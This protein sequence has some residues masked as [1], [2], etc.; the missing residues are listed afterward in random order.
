MV[1]F[2]FLFCYAVHCIIPSFAINSLG[3][4]ELVAVQVRKK[5]IVYCCSHCLWVFCFR[6]LFCYEVHCKF[7]VVQSTVLVAS[8]LLPSVSHVAVTR[9]VL[10]LFL[11]VSL[12]WSSVCDCGNSWSYSLTFHRNFFFLVAC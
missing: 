8:L 4:R 5:F 3:K 1:C 2:R 10:C 7:L 12:F 11:V 9:I 6:S